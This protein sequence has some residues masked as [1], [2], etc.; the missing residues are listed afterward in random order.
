MRG[1]QLQDLHFTYKDLVDSNEHYKDEG[2][3]H[4]GARPVGAIGRSRLYAVWTGCCWTTCRWA[5][6]PAGRSEGKTAGGPQRPGRPVERGRNNQLE[7]NSLLNHCTRW[8][9]WLFR[10]FV[11]F[12]VNTPQNM[13]KKDT[14]WGVKKK[15]KCNKEFSDTLTLL[16]PASRRNCWTIF[17]IAMMLAVPGIIA[18]SND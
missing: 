7:N 2:G 3:T 15:K 14:P 17:F 6:G 1:K 18:T 16:M 12:L 13:T 11:V 9:F 8:Q 10:F 5:E 4:G